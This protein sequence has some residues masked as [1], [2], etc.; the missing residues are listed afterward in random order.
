MFASVL[1]MSSLN[2]YNFIGENT[3]PNRVYVLLPIQ[4]LTPLE[5][6]NSRRLSTFF[7]IAT[8]FSGYQVHHNLQCWPGILE[9]SLRGKSLKKFS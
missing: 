7:D 5:P 9:T 4:N 6:E 2:R 8:A 3:L 1:T